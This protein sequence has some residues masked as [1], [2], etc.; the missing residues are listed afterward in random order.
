MRF[1]YKLWIYRQH[2]CTILSL[3]SGWSVE[4]SENSG[5]C[6]FAVSDQWNIKLRLTKKISKRFFKSIDSKKPTEFPVRE[7]EPNLAEAKLV[8]QAHWSFTT[9]PLFAKEISFLKNLKNPYDAI[10]ENINEGISV[11]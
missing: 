5:S 4:W 2:D 7:T 8:I 1:K 9:D 11:A 6:H 3:L 10:H